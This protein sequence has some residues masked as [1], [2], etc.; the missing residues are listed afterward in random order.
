M[1]GSL[2]VGTLDVEAGTAILTTANTIGSIALTGTGEL[3]FTSSAAL[4]DAAIS[5]SGVAKLAAMADVEISNDI[6]SALRE[7][8]FAVENGAVLKLDGGLTFRTLNG[9][10]LNFMGTGTHGKGDGTG[11]VDID[12]S[13][14]AMSTQS[15]NLLN[16]TGVT[17]GTSIADNGSFDNLLSTPHIVKIENNG[18]LDLTGQD[19]L[20]FQNLQGVGALLNSGPHEDITLLTC[21]LE[22][23]RPRVTLISLWKV[24]VLAG[25][26]L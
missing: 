15:N 13:I 8:S 25:R 3:E 5:I 1:H 20:T 17:L 26:S 21:E 2:H 12:G 6:T 24:V 18:V 19:N 14:G 7:E 23:V 11:V 22:S 4:G 16:I 9:V 10:T